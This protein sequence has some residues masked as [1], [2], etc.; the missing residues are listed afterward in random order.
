MG[1]LPYSCKFYDYVLLEDDDR[2]HYDI[3]HQMLSR[4]VQ[5]NSN[6]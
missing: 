5:V 3:Y 2:Q 1:W 4:Q 6:L